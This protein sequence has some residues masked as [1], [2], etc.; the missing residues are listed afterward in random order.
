MYI[1]MCMYT[2]RYSDF[3]VNLHAVSLPQVWR[4]FIFQKELP[5]KFFVGE[6]FG[7]NLWRGVHGRTNDKIIGGAK[8]IFR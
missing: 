4:D 1:Y 6:T 2:F 5:T 8:Y 7:E 3:Y